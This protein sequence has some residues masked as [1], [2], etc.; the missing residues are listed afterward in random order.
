MVQSAEQQQPSP[1]TLR[2]AIHSRLTSYAA[3][4]GLPQ[5]APPPGFQALPQI[6]SVVPEALRQQR[7]ADLAAA[8]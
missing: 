7:T 8:R 6:S 2:E 4:R 1:V 3:E 5:L